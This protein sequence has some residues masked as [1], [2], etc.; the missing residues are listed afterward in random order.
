MK[1]RFILQSLNRDLMSCNFSHIYIEKDALEH[2]N[3]KNILK[4]FKNST[5]VKINNYKEL[6]CRAHQDFSLQKQST[7]IILAVKRDNF[8]YKGADVCESFSNDYF[9]YTSSV[10]N[11]LYNCD[12]CYLKGMYPS[13]NIVIFVNIEDILKEVDNI[14]KKHPLYLCISYDTDL[15]AL[16]GITSFASIWI[17]FAKEHPNLKIELRTKSTAFSS[18]HHIK[19]L[20]NFIL[21]WTLSPQSI[22][23]LYEAKT[24]S[25]SARLQSINEALK[26]GWNVRLC[27]DPLLCV[28]DW[29]QT[30]KSFIDEVFNKI[31]YELI[32]DV[33]IGVFRVSKDYLKRM[34]KNSPL[35]LL[36]SYP[37]ECKN[38]VCSYPD[39]CSD[40]MTGFV[41]DS[42]CS[43]ISE[44]KIYI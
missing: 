10:M 5:V 2:P 32:Q 26:C 23:E 34:K 38:G 18:I 14:L 15:L 28:P 25:L 1:G 27:F 16:E 20:Q 11:C 39:S 24:P 3:T 40:E 8:I 13:A 19:P 17:N 36:L 44:E 21:A 31:P 30:Y 22:I 6:F 33:S 7:N 12:Y 41:H 37:F 9:Y 4:H 43:Y 29:K 42:V 35:S